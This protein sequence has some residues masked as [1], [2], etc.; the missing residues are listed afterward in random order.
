MSKNTKL[1]ITCSNLQ[2]SNTGPK[3]ALKMK[4]SLRNLNSDICIVVNSHCDDHTLNIL[5]KDYKLELAQFN[6]DGILVKN[7]GIL[8]LTKKNSGFISKNLKS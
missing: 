7:Q 3:L 6:I 5:K 1:K 4:H 2:G 8:V